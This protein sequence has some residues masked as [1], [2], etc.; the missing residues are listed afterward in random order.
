MN[1]KKP[2]RRAAVSGIVTL[3]L[4]VLLTFVLFFIS[5]FVFA[6][7]SQGAK[8]LSDFKNLHGLEILFTLAF[9]FLG[10]IF[11]FSIYFAYGFVVLGRR[12]NNKLLNVMAWIKIILSCVMILALLIGYVI[13]M[14]YAASAQE[15][16]LNKETQINAASAAAPTIVFSI[17]VVILLIFIVVV[18]NITISVLF[19]V[20]LLKL[21]EQVELSEP[22]GILE[23][24]GSVVNLASAAAM[25]IEII[26]FFK[27]SKKLEK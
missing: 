16:N 20:S 26:M 22:S 11:I 27:V 19:G 7:Q 24:I 10:T 15:I 5:F 3:S 13:L 6:P 8:E 21:K 23:I 14:V 2:L 18:I 1:N 9:I 25:I 17:M 4:I 12:F